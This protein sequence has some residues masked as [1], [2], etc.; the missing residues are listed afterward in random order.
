MIMQNDL[1][2][3]FSL[4]SGEYEKKAIEVLRS[5][6]Y[7]LGKEVEQFEKEWADYI[8]CKYCV[9]LA[10]GLDSLWISVHL[11]NIG[12]GDEVIVCANAYIACI[13]GIT[14]ND[15]VPVFVEPD[16]YGNIDAQKIESVITPKTKAILAVHLY[17]QAC[18]MTV[19][20][21]IAH[22]YNLQVIEDCAQSHGGLW[23]GKKTG[24]F[25]KVGCFSFYPSK[26]LGAFGDAGCIVTNDEELA[27]KFRIFRNY[28]SEKRYHNQV[29]GRNSRLDELQA[30]LLRI[31]LTHLDKLNAE[32]CK[33]A[34]RYMD[35]ITNPIIR[36]PQVRPG[37]YPVWHQ[38]VIRCKERDEL[39]GYLD[40]YGIKTL[41]H[42]PILP[43]LSE[44]YG[45]L[46]KKEGDHPI[47]ERYAKEILSL[48][49]YNGMKEKEITM[50]I[51][52]VNG[53]DPTG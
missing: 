12:P 30:G 3:Q 1:Q 23:R 14:I 25:G 37:A 26:N 53:F 7:I 9:G 21:E 4:Y 46:G 48:P 2:R 27:K 17:G 10:S 22:Q 50:V 36:L 16:R 24:A 34:G 19:I 18:D 33:I 13:M 51:D 35:G 44:A 31:K 5:G 11:L 28:G 39:I 49:L 20:M 38:F 40:R 29:I 8:G 32:R 41:I 15:A 42:Y 6:W 45:Y 47:A 52:A 43:Y